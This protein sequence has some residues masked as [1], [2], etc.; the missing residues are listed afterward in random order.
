[1]V[2][3]GAASASAVE[4]SSASVDRMIRWLISLLLPC[5][6]SGSPP[7]QYRPRHAEDRLPRHARVERPA[8]AGDRVQLGRIDAAV[9]EYRLGDVKEYDLADDVVRVVRPGAVLDDLEEAAL[10]R[11]RTLD[12]APRLYPD[13]GRLREARDL[14]LVH[15]GRIVRRS[16]VHP[17]AELEP[18]DVDHVLPGRAHIVERVLVPVGAARDRHEHDRRWVGAPR[19][20]ERE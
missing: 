16:L 12:R 10:H 13:A 15:L 7:G 17:L 8:E 2:S 1:M 20:E 19:V 5:R 9:G 11:D 6:P 18:D 14:E 4:H 3:A